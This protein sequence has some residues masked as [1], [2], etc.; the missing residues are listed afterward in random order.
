MAT[1]VCDGFSTRRVLV[2]PEMASEW[3]L[4][5]ENN[6][7]INQH[8]VSLM[9]QQI[10][11]GKWKITHQGIAFYADGSLADG[12]HRLAAIASGDTP[13]EMMVT[14][15][16]S[17]E[18]IHAIDSGRPRSITNVLNFMGM[19]LSQTE[20][21]ICR[22]LWQDYHAAR[23]ETV[24]NNQCFDTGKFAIFCEHVADA[25]AFA[26]PPKACRGLSNSAVSAAIAS[27]WFTQS[28]VD[29]ER[30]KSLL[31]SGVGAAPDESAAIK[32]REFLLT[33]PLNAG[34]S[35]A[36]QELFMRSCTALRAFLEGRSLSK[37][38][39]RADARFPIPDCP[40]L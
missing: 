2:T 15:G 4:K 35:E 5:N 19:K 25:M 34:G 37:L 9:R 24:W 17:Q 18:L 40:W 28:H 3:L 20:V 26:V 36:R 8:R 23:N 7:P 31:H 1:A 33:T 39:C 27:A 11:E 14:W 12:Q 32:L 10:A 38:Y 16:L 29:L 6:R 22:A 30:F 13:V 21:A